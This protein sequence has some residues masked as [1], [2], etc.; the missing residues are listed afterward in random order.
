MNYVECWK[1]TCY[2]KASSDHGVSGREW[3]D[4]AG[5]A[6]PGH[7]GPYLPG[8][9]EGDEEPSK[10]LQQGNLGGVRP[11][12]VTAGQRGGWMEGSEPGA[13]RTAGKQFS[14]KCRE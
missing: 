11:R 10:A 4:K 7:A 13:G 3:G 14:Q 6:A 8:L 9:A 12:R 1:A 5:E 2:S